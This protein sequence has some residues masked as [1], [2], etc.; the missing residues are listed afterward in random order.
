M[1]LQLLLVLELKQLCLRLALT[2]M[3]VI[4]RQSLFLL[5]WEVSIFIDF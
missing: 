3:M 1:V 2:V 5:I 4:A